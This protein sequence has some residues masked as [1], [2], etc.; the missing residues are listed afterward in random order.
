MEEVPT[1]AASEEQAASS[2]RSTNSCNA[3][4]PSTLFAAVVGVASAA[5]AAFAFDSASGTLIASDAASA[6]QTQE[7]H[8]VIPGLNFRRRMGQ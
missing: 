4:K 2:G 8:L 6:A 5:A 7:W 3:L 1:G